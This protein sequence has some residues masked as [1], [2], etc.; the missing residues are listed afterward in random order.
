MNQPKPTAQTAPIL[1]RFSVIAFDMDGVLVDSF[2]CWWELLSDSLVRQGKPP[3]TREEFASTWGQDME[4][5]RRTYFP[6]W[7]TEEV[8]AHYDALFPRYA[9]LVEVEPGAV[10]ALAGLRAQGKRLAV[11]TNSPMDI[12]TRL[13]EGAALA[14]YFDII[15]GVDL[16]AEG[17]P[18]PDLLHLIARESGI[19]PAEMAYVGDSIFDEEAA[20]SAGVFFVGYQ[21]PGDA[22]IERLDELVGA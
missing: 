3:L 8:I 13:L 10:A 12:A 7:T 21:R 19:T 17:K 20:R 14:G 18:A 1:E 15:A 4:A 5:D 9:H 22:R 6:E 16:V 2:R 11:A